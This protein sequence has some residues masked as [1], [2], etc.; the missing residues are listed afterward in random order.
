[1]RTDAVRTWP[2]HQGT[3][4]ICT[5]M[6]M[7]LVGALGGAL[8]FLIA[9]ESMISANH[10]AAQ[11][12]LYGADA[13][14]ERAIGDLRRLSDWRDVPGAAVD[15][16]A[17]DFRDGT[18][19]PRL[20]DGAVLDLARLTAERQTESN[21][22]YDASGN[23]PIWRL[24]AHAALD[25]LVPA[26]LPPPPVYLVVWIA[27]DVEDADGDP[28]RDSNDV[29]MIRSEAFGL[30]GTRRRVDATLAREIRFEAIEPAEAGSPPPGRVRRNEVRV[31]SWREAR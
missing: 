18:A 2:S 9:T 5:L 11:Q 27:D 3:A 24:F 28:L 4:L 20:A 15:S 12:A 14:I 10:R 17:P 19:A 26:D 23:R 13:A 30:R 16:A 1:M 29:L 8:V 25:R 6:V 21:A 31:M 22:D 7:S